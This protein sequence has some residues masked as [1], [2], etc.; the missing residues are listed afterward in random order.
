MGGQ[1]LA[2]EAVGSPSLEILTAQLDQLLGWLAQLGSRDLEVQFPSQPAVLGVWCFCA[3]QPRNASPSSCRDLHPNS[4]S[5]TIFYSPVLEAGEILN[6]TII[7][8]TAFIYL[9]DWLVCCECC[10][11]NHCYYVIWGE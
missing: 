7:Q 10:T 5:S 3:L 6:A 2:H 1:I 11:Q 4:I 8:V 9:R